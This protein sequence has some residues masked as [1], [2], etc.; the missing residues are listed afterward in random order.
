[1]DR[2]GVIDRIAPTMVFETLEDAC[3]AFEVT[4]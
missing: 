4:A 2:A 3:R 1:L